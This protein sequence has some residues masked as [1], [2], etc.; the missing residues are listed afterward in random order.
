MESDRHIF[1]WDD[2]NREKCQR[3]DVSISEAESLF[4]RDPAI[5]PDIK[6]SSAEKRYLAIGQGDSGRYLFAAFTYRIND[7]GWRVIRLISVRYMHRKEVIHYL[8]Y[9]KKS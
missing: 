7:E 5:Y 2:A 3:H 1:D 8:S 6:H 9:E 4:I